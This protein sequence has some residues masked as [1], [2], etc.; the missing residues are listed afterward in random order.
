MRVVA[1]VL[2]VCEFSSTFSSHVVEDMD[3]DSEDSAD[4]REA[5]KAVNDSVSKVEHLS[6]VGLVFALY[7]CLHP[8]MG[9]VCFVI[10][11]S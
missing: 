5:L 11:W 4:E 10:C 1:S 9:L 7:A 8:C 6:F 2:S 3:M